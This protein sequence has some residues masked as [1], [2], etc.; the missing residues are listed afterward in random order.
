MNDDIGSL[1]LLTL[2]TA[3][4]VASFNPEEEAEEEA[5]MLAVADL[6]KTPN[7]EQQ[8][9][10]PIPS[11]EQPEA[12]TRVTLKREVPLTPT[13]DESWRAKTPISGITY[14]LLL[15]RYFMFL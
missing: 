3:V 15:F 1:I 14:S 5:D 13:A 9:N 6:P 12:L 7:S 8:R 4:L 11:T 2:V 10:T